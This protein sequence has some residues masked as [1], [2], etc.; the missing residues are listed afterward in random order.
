MRQKK[1]NKGKIHDDNNNTREQKKKV[2]RKWRPRANL[3]TGGAWLAA[4][5]GV[6]MPRRNVGWLGGS[7]VEGPPD[8][9]WSQ[10]AGLDGQ[11]V[12]ACAIVDHSWRVS[13]TNSRKAIRELLIGS[14]E[15]AEDY[16]T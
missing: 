2:V 9:T 16:L 6:L 14:T 3:L 8:F 1:N 15:G 13:K 12:N 11:H 7:R 5:A 10:L 4:L